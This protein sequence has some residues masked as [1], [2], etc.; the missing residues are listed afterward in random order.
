MSI[1]SGLVSALA[2]VA[3]LAAGPAMAQEIS[4]EAWEEL[5]DLQEEIL[6]G[7]DAIVKA[8]LILTDAEG[9]AFWP[10]YEEYRAAADAIQERQAGLV[11]AY[12]AN[13]ETMSEP[14][15]EAFLKEWLAIDRADLEMREDYAERIRK[16]LPARKAIRF[17][18]VESKLDA[19]MD[20]EATLRIPLVE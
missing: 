19:I 11:E 17:F 2:A 9:Q 1:K 7:R 3:L 20:L 8:N 16:V 6:E 10:V 5:R 14:K 15:A 18:Q 13:F 12:A 4:A